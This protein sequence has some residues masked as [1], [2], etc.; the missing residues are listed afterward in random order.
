M[1]FDRKFY[2]SYFSPNADT[3][4]GGMTGQLVLVKGLA[5]MDAPKT[6]WD[7]AM[8]QAVTKG[9]CSEQLSGLGQ[10]RQALMR[11]EMEDLIYDNPG[12]DLSEIASRVT[13]QAISDRRNLSKDLGGNLLPPDVQRRKN[14]NHAANLPPPATLM[15]A[16]PAAPAAPV[17]LALPAPNAVA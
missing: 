1:R 2:T 9:T 5:T 17:L 8:R 10:A 4:R 12:V 11:A 15:I 14:F 3:T 16:P 13:D 7:A 6:V